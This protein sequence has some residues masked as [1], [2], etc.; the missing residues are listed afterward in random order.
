[1]QYFNKQWENFKKKSWFG[2]ASDILFVLLIVAM[3]IPASRREIRVFVSGLLASGPKTITEEKQVSLSPADYQ[4]SF[5]DM[6]G[7]EFRLS[8]FGG[9]PVFLNFWA[10]WCPPCIAEMPD[11][12]DLYDTFGQQAA[13]ILLSD[14]DPKVVQSF[15]QRKGF[16]IP[17]YQLRYSVP[18][19]FA[20]P[21]IPVTFVISA[22]GRIV[23]R[24][25]GAAKWNSSSMIAVMH[26]LLGQ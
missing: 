26:D 18:E 1:M 14:E 2:K 4:W 24:K 22:E 15:M 25:T 12:Q 17:V 8:D 5:T 21:S 9:K 13:F 19:V 3:L 20:S 6:D 16:N 10:T 11:I 7:R 23:I